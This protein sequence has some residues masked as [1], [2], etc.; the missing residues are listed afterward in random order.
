MYLIDISYIILLVNLPSQNQANNV[1]L[2]AQGFKLLFILEWYKIERLL[3]FG[4]VLLF[5]ALCFHLWDI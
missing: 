5:V 2:M 4:I 1:R 3:N